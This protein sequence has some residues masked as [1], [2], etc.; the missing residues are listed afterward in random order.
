MK[1]F[2]SPGNVQKGMV[3]IIALAILIVIS[4]IAIT[5]MKTAV[6]EE[7]MAINMQ[8]SNSVFQAAETGIDQAMRDISLL[9]SVTNTNISAT[10]TATFADDSPVEA[11]VDV[12]F[13]RESLFDSGATPDA[14]QAGGSWQ[15]GG[16]GNEPTATRYYEAQSE[17]VFS[18]NNAIKTNITQGFFYCTPG[19]Q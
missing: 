7:R 14:T 11:S 19:C 8:N 10:K 1:N 4:L 9:A 2:K 18:D 3:L 15:G 12:V 5:S 13:I 17:A 6:L 16:V